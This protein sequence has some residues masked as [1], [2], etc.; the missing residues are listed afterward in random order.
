MIEILLFVS[1]IVLAV[2]LLLSR[3]N[4][5]LVFLALC[6]GNTLLEFAERNI[7]YVSSQ[8]EHFSLISKYNVTQTAI[9]FIIIAVPV[10][11]V[12]IFSKHDQGKKK[13]PIQALPALATGFLA[14]IIIIPMLSISLQNSIATNRIW[15]RLVEYQVFVVAVGVLISLFVVI[16]SSR[17]SHVSKHHKS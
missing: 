9:K 13:W 4:A 6:A 17:S 11:L 12:I 16:I 3:T 5:G 8:L 7:T 1:V 15:S 10:L 2:A 14:A